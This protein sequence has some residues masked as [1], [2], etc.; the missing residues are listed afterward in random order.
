MRDLDAVLQNRDPR[1]VF[2]G[3]AFFGGISKGK[4][5]EVWGPPGAGKTAL[6]F[7]MR[8]WEESYAD[9]LM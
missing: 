9:R 7:V 3:D 1:T 2:E 5:T 6:G 8:S 4:V